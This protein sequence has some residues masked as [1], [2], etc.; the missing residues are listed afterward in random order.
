MPKKK[1]ASKIV[2]TVVARAAPA[3]EGGLTKFDVTPGGGDR[4]GIVSRSEPGLAREAIFPCSI[5]MRRDLEERDMTAKNHPEEMIRRDLLATIM[6][7]TIC[8]VN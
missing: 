3:T 8:N 7:G 1:V 6:I 2:T 5:E 4:T